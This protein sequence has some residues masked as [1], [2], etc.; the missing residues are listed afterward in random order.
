VTTPLLTTKLHIPRF[1]AGTVLRSRL[2][3]RVN[4]GWRPE[5]V[6]VSAPA[7]F[8]KSTLLSTWVQ[9][10][11]EQTPGRTHVA[12]LS[13]DEGDNDLARFLTYFVAALQTIEGNLGQVVMGSLQSPGNLN[14]EVVLTMLLNEIAEFTDDVVIILDD[15]HLIESQPIDQALIFLLDHFPA[16]LHL[17]IATREDPLLPLARLRARGQL[18]ELRAAELRFTSS[19]AAEFLDQVMGLNLSEEDIAVLE[20]R[21]EGWIAGLQLAALSLQGKEDASTPVQTFSGSHRFVLDYL[22]EEVL[23]QQPE[24]IQTFLLQTAILD[25]L[26]DSLCDAITSRADGQVTLEMLERANLFI[27]PLDDERRWYRYHHLFAD[28]LRQRLRQTHP[29]RIPGLHRRA[30]EWYQQKE[31]V[32]D[33]IR[34]ALAGED[35]ERAADLAELAWPAWSENVPSLTWLSWVNDLPEEV[36]S[37]RPVLSFAYAQAL[38]NTGQLEAAETRLLDA[39]RW[40]E[41]TP[42]MADRPMVSP[43]KM[44]VV[45]EAQFRVLPAWIATTRA[46]QSQAMGDVQGTVKYVGRAL[47]LFPEDDHY[48]RAAVTGLLGLAYWANGD[49]EAAY[50]TF[51]DGFFQNI[52]DRI[53]GTFVL[54]D[55][56]KILGK[57]SEAER[58]CERGLKLAKA[59][60]PPM[61]IGTEDV[62][63]AIGEI[64]REQGYLETAAQDLRM[65]KKLGEQVELPD[66]RHRW[67]IAQAR[68]DASLGNLDAAIELLDEASRV[69]VRT[70]VPDVRP[71]ATMKARVWIKQGRLGEAQRWAQEQGLSVDDD[72]NYLAEFDHVTLA[73][74]LM[75]GHK[76]E[77]S[78]SIDEAASLLKRLLEAAETGKRMGSVIEI[79]VLQALACEAQ[80]DTLRALVPLERAL[81]LAQPE[82]YLRIFVDEGPP[83]EHLLH[84]A[85]SGG[86][87]QNYTRQLLATFTTSESSQSGPSVNQA[88][89][90][91]LIEPLSERELE[92]LQLIAEGLTN[93]EIADR[94]YLSLN[95]VKVHTRNIYGKLDVHHRAQAVARAREIGVLHPT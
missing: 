70:P 3:Q 64:H 17:I 1:R 32:S 89:N 53:K 39:E 77:D 68:L 75:A 44:V 79:L 63:S 46:Y 73:R 87:A 25:R 55:M 20:A 27:I 35:Y 71:I 83:M 36:V 86:I 74:L 9:Q 8:G 21:T 57:L 62:Y 52:H 30:S 10:A 60:D 93:R 50:R 15:Y 81:I 48:H 42:E 40:L 28:L 29:E 92:V 26:S 90:I 94:L 16:Q 76:R 5:H 18:A 33:A 51:S 43:N 88:A 6:L 2:I 23:E 65:C 69:Y 82:C 24:S 14:V 45:D 61:P 34:H 38:L 47:D 78:D 67:C 54:A 41:S 91:E 80:G 4:A 31:M 72:L 85:L 37:V 11:E 84:K 56:Q 49:L 12:W 7:G 95:T 59:Y 66:W 19:E 13:L 22:I 58:T